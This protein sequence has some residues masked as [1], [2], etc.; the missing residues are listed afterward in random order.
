MGHKLLI[1]LFGCI[2][3]TLSAKSQFEDIDKLIEKIKIP[4]HGLTKEQIAKLKNPF[5]DQRTLKK[6][7]IKQK[8]INK[9]KR[10]KFTL[11]LLSIFDNRAKINDRWYKI[12]DKIGSYRLSYIDPDQAF[13]ILKA[14]GK[15]LRLFLHKHKYK[16]SL[17][18]ISEG[19]KK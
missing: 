13:V 19:R 1:A 4:R 16:R 18:Q 12:G 5:I 6:I 2:L 11:R 17:F 8:I 9:L 7:V 3:I 14:K 10:K 15:Q